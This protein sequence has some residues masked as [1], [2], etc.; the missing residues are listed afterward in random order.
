MVGEDGK[1][2]EWKELAKTRTT[3][4][5]RILGETMIDS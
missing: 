2:G 5:R 4:N 3:E 1:R